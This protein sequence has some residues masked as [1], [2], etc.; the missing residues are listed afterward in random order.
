MKNINFAAAI[1]IL[2][3]W[4]TGFA[5]ST[6]KII[7]NAVKNQTDKKTTKQTPA[8]KVF[9]LKTV[10][11][12][13]KVKKAQLIKHIVAKKPKAL[14]FLVKKGSLLANIQA[15]SHKYHYRL[16]WDVVNPQTELKADFH[17]LNGYFVK[18][19]SD[20]GL[21]RK[22]TNTFPVAPPEVGHL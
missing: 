4:T 10:K 20:T 3:F 2:A 22:I 13:V 12:P 9:K 18:A 19:P 21:L 6:H 11:K 14:V 8:P 7:P 16:I 1:F 5:Q 17:V 15:F